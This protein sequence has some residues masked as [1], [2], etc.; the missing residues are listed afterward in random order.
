MAK[1]LPPNFF[2]PYKVNHFTDSDGDGDN[3]IFDSE[4][5]AND[6]GEKSAAEIKFRFQK[7][8]EGLESNDFPETKWETCSAS[9]FQVNDISNPEKIGNDLYQPTLYKCSFA[10]DGM[11]KQELYVI[12]A[13]HQTRKDV[14]IEVV[15][16]ANSDIFSKVEKDFQTF[17]K[18]LSFEL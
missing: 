4:P 3:W 16:I 18:S 17:M 9:G 7:V 2:G 11:P 13:I 12:H 15:L 14:G 10:L 5:I 6:D 8:P 1:D